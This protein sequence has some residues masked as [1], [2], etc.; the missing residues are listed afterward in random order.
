[1]GFFAYL[2]VAPI[3]LGTHFVSL[4]S[5]TPAIHAAPLFASPSPRG[6][7]L[8]RSRLRSISPTTTNEITLYLS[9]SLS[10]GRFGQAPLASCPAVR[11][12]QG[13][14]GTA[15]WYLVA[16]QLVDRFDDSSTTPPL[17]LPVDRASPRIFGSSGCR[18]SFCARS[19][20]PSW[21]RANHRELEIR[22]W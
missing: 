15:D 11:Q 3:F 4:G 1:M 14:F 8:P 13:R 18:R 21:I 7:D 17:W 20:T 22:C 16:N 9:A 6:S 10:P 19:P 2:P 12:S 5:R